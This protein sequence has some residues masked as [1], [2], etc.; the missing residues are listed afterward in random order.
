MARGALMKKTMKYEI[1]N[2]CRVEADPDGS[3]PALIQDLNTNNESVSIN[4][5]NRGWKN[6][7]KVRVIIERIEKGKA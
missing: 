1:L 6:G 4:L 7:D 2:N 3:Y 5:K